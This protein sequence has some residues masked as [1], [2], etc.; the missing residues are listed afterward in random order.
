MT[1]TLLGQAQSVGA[2]AQSLAGALADTTDHVGTTLQGLA[3]HAEQRG[4]FYCS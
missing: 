2:L 1:T 3:E 4:H